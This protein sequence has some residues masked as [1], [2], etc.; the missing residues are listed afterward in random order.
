MLWPPTLL[1]V[2]HPNADRSCQFCSK[3]HSAS[4]TQQPNPLDLFLHQIELF[5]ICFRLLS[6]ETGAHNLDFL[7]AGS[8]IHVFTRLFKTSSHQGAQYD[9][10]TVVFPLQKDLCQEYLTIPNTFVHESV[11]HYYIH[12]NCKQY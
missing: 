2:D 10:C 8:L 7:F 3:D 9:Y 6:S 5:F 1:P 4:P 11:H 12:N